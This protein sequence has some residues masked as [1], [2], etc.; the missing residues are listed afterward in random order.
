M[1]APEWV[2]QRFS[3]RTLPESKVLPIAPADV[4][5]S[6]GQRTPWPRPRRWCVPSPEAR[7]SERAASRSR[8]C[9]TGTAAPEPKR[10]DDRPHAPWLVS[11][12]HGASAYP[13]PRSQRIPS[14]L[15]QPESVSE[16]SKHDRA[17]SLPLA[18]FHLLV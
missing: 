1:V 9:R 6:A 18:P 3:T 7:W 12:T 14:R 16:A 11:P 2:V 17:L 15:H 10:S 13:H 5:P 4:P 8:P